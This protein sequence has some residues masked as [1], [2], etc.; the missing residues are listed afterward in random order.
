MAWPDRLIRSGGRGFQAVK[1]SPCFVGDELSCLSCHSM[2]D[3]PP[4]DQL[5]SGMR[6]NRACLQ[7]HSD[8]ES[9]LEAHSHHEPDSPGSLCYNCHMPHTAFNLLK[10]TRSHQ[11]YNPD[12]EADLAAGR[13]NACNL[14]HLDRSLEWTAGFLSEWYQQPEADLSR[15]ERTISAAVVGVLK[16]DA[17]QRALYAWSMGWPAAQEASG[18]RWMSPLLA[19][20]LADS[21]P[22][23][24]AVATRSLRTLPDYTDFEVDPWRPN[25]LGGP[26]KKRALAR[27]EEAPPAATRRGNEVLVDGTGDPDW[28]IIRALLAERDDRVVQIIE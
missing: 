5:I 15:E 21:Y 28:E 3:A 20:L 6:G 19:I 9:K 11:I 22:A 2:H 1:R 23:V 18:R 25:A 7:C 13:P 12:L 26:A 4:D 27:W 10:A 14:C 8:F 24:R 17:M 16:G